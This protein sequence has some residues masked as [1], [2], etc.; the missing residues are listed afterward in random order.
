MSAW[1]QGRILDTCIFDESG[2]IACECRTPKQAARI[3][4]CVNACAGV[5][6]L[7]PGIVAEMA[8]ELRALCERLEQY[9]DGPT[10][11]ARAL[12]ARLEGKQ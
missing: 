8:E 6:H 11:D 5:E 2:R 10:D 12:L 9:E 4:A 3:I 7:E 1:E